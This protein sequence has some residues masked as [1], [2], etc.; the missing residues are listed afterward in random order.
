MPILRAPCDVRRPDGSV[1]ISSEWE[2]GI[3]ICTTS[4]PDVVVDPNLGNGVN[5]LDNVEFDVNTLIPFS[6]FNWDTI[7]GMDNVNT[8][9]MNTYGTITTDL[10][11]KVNKATAKVADCDSV[12][13]K[14]LAA[15]VTRVEDAVEKIDNNIKSIMSGQ[16]Q[17]QLEAYG[18]GL[19]DRNHYLIYREINDG[20]WY[21]IM[22]PATSPPV[23]REA[24]GPFCDLAIL[25]S[26]DAQIRELIPA[27]AK[28]L[29]TADIGI[30]AA[31]MRMYQE[32]ELASRQDATGVASSVLGS[33]EGLICDDDIPLE[34]HPYCPVLHIAPGFATPIGYRLIGNEYW[35]DT[36]MAR[37]ELI[38]DK[39]G[40]QPP[41][42]KPRIDPPIID[43]L[44]EPPADCEIK[45][46]A[47]AECC[48]DV[49]PPSVVHN[50]GDN[51]VINTGPPIDP[52]KKD[53]QPEDDCKR[54]ARIK[55]KGMDI[56][57][58]DVDLGLLALSMQ[59]CCESLTARGGGGD[60]E[61]LYSDV[62][63]ARIDTF[64][65]NNGLQQ[66]GELV[67]Q[68]L[69]AAVEKYIAMSLRED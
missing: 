49:C 2:R 27:K 30:Q 23:G 26:I 55:I 16:I 53:K 24:Y 25:N 59:E 7:D 67:P 69:G 38:D 32:A 17:P 8:S 12:V 65:D 28:P 56:S 39:G 33:H 45:S 20:S 63:Q 21:P 66:Y 58:C 13:V 10:A 4:S 50:Y 61:Y 43:P 1:G 5:P 29:L 14:N 54:E 11:A 52:L 62:G 6:E 35:A 18:Q 40:K 48:P 15:Q 57:T 60:V 51:N 44:I 34:G 9:I 3:Q 31:L 46:K 36:V 42:I 64:L 47:V 22:E 68:T 19:C 41:P 37:Y